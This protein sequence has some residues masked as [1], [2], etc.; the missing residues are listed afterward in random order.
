MT[1]YTHVDEI[2]AA[3]RALGHHWFDRDTMSFFDSKV[4]GSVHYGRYFI[5]SE[6]PWGVEKR[7]YTIRVADERGAVDTIGAPAQYTSYTQAAQALDRMVESGELPKYAEGVNDARPKAD[8]FGDALRNFSNAV[9]WYERR[10][11]I[12]PWTRPDEWH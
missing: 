12:P 11:N 4:Y 10:T 5:S 3:N 6:V 1:V 2:K 9:K 8:T 7:R